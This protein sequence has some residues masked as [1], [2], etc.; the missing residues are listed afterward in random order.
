MDGLKLLFFCLN[1]QI[2]FEVDYFLLDEVPRIHA[3]VAEN[4]L[5]AV[6]AKAI[7]LTYL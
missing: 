3:W 7:K 4:C 1:V 5:L 6:A 2:N